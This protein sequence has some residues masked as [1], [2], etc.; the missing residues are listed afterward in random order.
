[1]SGNEQMKIQNIV[2]NQLAKGTQPKKAFKL[3]LRLL[4]AIADMP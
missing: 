3:V 4:K 1:M 2:L